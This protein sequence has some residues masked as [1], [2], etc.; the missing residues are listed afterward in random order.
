MDPSSGKSPQAWAATSGLS[1]LPVMGSSSNRPATTASPVGEAPLP[2]SSTTPGPRGVLLSEWL[3]AAPTL[4]GCSTGVPPPERHSLVQARRLSPGRF[5]ARV[6][7]VRGRHGPS[8][9]AEESRLNL[10]GEGRDSGL[11]QVSTCC[12][13]AP[14]SGGWGGPADDTSGPLRGVPPPQRGRREEPGWWIC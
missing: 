7:S 12:H 10:G 9:T 8:F 5:R 6:P 2:A 11:Q 1:D 3:L 13:S 14:E 4:P